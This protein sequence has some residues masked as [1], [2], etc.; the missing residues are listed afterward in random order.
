MLEKLKKLKNNAEN[1]KIQ[2]NLIK[3]GLI[4][5][6]EEIWD[7]SKEEKETEQPNQIVNIAEKLLEF[8]IQQRGQSLK[9]VTPDQM[10]NRWPIILAQ[11]NAVNNSEILKNEIRQLLYSGYRSKKLPKQVYKPLIDII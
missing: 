4:N 5:F 9:I 10:L 6:K 2:V 1:N 8:N 11:L 3:S 7:M